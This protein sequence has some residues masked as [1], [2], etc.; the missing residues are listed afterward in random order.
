VQALL[1]LRIAGQNPD[2][3]GFVPLNGQHALELGAVSDVLC[4]SSKENA[5]QFTVTTSEGRISTLLAEVGAASLENRFLSVSLK[6]EDLPECLTSPAGTV[7][8]YLAAERFGPRD[9][10][11]TQSLPLEALSLGARGEFSAEVFAA[12]ERKEIRRAVAHGANLSET[13]LLRQNV[14]S[15]MGEWAPKIQIRAETFPDKNIALLRFQ[16]RDLMSEWMRPT[17]VGF[18]VSHSLPIVLAGLLA[19]ESG[20]LIVDSPESHLHP[21]GQ[22]AIGRFLA[23]VA[24]SGVQV[25]LETHSDHVLNGIR[26][27]VAS[28][29]TSL[30]IED[31][32]IH[33]IDGRS[34]GAA[35]IDEIYMTS[36]GGLSRW[37]TGFFD[38]I[39]NDLAAIFALR[40]QE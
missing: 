24:A 19:Q 20:I 33:N 35:A 38:Q 16:Q 6:G 27:A 12:F 32:V 34:P 23:I 3:P 5:I 40:K 22:S 11:L 14:E 37:P 29:E 15:W 2:Q 28:A 10:Q 30:G 25:I 17:N 13:P 7:F 4:H 21:A 26:I 9:I 36:S 1:L 8:A 31:V 18:G 39:E